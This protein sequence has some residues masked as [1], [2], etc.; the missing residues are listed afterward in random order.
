MRPLSAGSQRIALIEFVVFSNACSRLHWG[1]RYSTNIDI[2]FCNVMGAGERGVGFT[3]V[4][5][6]IYKTN[7]IWSLVPY[8]SSIFVKRLTGGSYRFLLLVV[9]ENHL[10]RILGLFGGLGDNPADWVSN[11]FY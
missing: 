7:I 8:R 3:L 1:Y 9:D 11:H 4:T 10:G 2:E 5:Q 6:L